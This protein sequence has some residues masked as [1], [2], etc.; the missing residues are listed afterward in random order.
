MYVRD[1]VLGTTT[2]CRAPAAS[3]SGT[4]TIAD[5]SDDGRYVVFVSDA[6]NLAAG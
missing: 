4:R 3:R 5:M 2:R 6:T 1:T